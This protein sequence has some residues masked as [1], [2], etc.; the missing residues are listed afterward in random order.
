MDHTG[1]G[2]LLTCVPSPSTTRSLNFLKITCLGQI[3]KNEQYDR[4]GQN[5]ANRHYKSQ[6]QINNISKQYD[7]LLTKQKIFHLNP[8]T[9]RQIKRRFYTQ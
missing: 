4:W 6:V 5:K 7:N 3:K 2:L 1:L 9:R 8:E